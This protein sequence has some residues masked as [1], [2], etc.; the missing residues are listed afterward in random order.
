MAVQVQVEDA[1]GE[2]VILLTLPFHPYWNA[3]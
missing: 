1:V 3:C 2:T